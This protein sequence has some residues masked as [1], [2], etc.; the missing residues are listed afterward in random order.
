MERL[1]KT[2]LQILAFAMTFSLSVAC[3]QIGELVGE[4]KNVN[5]NTPALTKLVI[6]DS[7]NDASIHVWGRC[8]PEDC[9]WGTALGY[10]Y[11]RTV[12]DS[13]ATAAHAISAFYR[14]NFSE[15]V[16]IVHLISPGRLQVETMTRFTDSSGRTSYSQVDTFSR[17]V[18]PNQ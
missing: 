2:A 16:V 11:G 14:T 4:W 17:A 3:A 8:H 1:L 6:T 10:L 15:T 18:L 7:Q 5:T 13:L 9:D 12:R